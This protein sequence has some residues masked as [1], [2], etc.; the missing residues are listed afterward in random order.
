MDGPVHLGPG[1]MEKERKRMGCDIHLHVE[2]K[3]EG[4][5]HHYDHPN[6]DR[7]YDLFAK[8]ANVRNRHEVIPISDQRGLPEDIAFTTQFDAARWAGDAH[9]HSYLT[10][11]EIAILN[12][13][14]IKNLFQRDGE[15]RLGGWRPQT[16]FGYFFGD[17]H[18]NCQCWPD[19]VE[20]VRFVFWFDN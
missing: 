1:G 15:G 10:I 3:A 19:G 6:I 13:W 14:G 4:K 9:S 17:S 5:W 7:N 20:D 16:D 12:K 11:S 18:E 8:M 2:F